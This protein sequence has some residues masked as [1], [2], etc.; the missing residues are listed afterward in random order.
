MVLPRPVKIHVPK[1]GPGG[2]KAVAGLKLACSELEDYGAPVLD[3]IEKIRNPERAREALLGRFRE[4]TVQGFKRWVRWNTGRDVPSS[5]TE[6][7]D[8]LYAREEEGIG[9]SVPLAISKAVAWFDGLAGIGTEQMS[10][11]NRLTNLVV[12]ELIKKLEKEPPPT[13]TAPRVLSAFLPAL[14]EVV[15]DEEAPDVLRVAAWIKL[16]KV[17]SSLRFDDVVH[18]K[19]STFRWYDGQLSATLLRTK[20][21]GAGKRVRHLPM[22]VGRH[23]WTR[24]YGC[25]RLGTR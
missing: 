21:T 16:L 4:S 5:P 12:Q 8:Y 9:P 22:F 14:E 24:R 3:E 2:E 25:W 11:N 13:K 19:L 7:V 1:L 15:M 6:L 17:W 10:M 23:C 18:L 20:S